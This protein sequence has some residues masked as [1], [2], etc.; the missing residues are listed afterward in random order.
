MDI[1]QIIY[2]CKIMNSDKIK[3]ICEC[4]FTCKKSLWNASNTKN[5]FQ[6][7][8]KHKDIN[9]IYELDESKTIYKLLPEKKYYCFIR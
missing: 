7:K 5:I 9:Y 4:R 1:L 3:Y 2:V 8:W 6:E